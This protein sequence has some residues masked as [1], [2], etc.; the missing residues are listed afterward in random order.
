MGRKREGRG[1]KEEKSRKRT[2]K[3]VKTVFFLNKGL[4]SFRGRRNE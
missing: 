1:R 4:L 2:R 3:K